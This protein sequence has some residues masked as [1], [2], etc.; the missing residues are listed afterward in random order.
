MSITNKICQLC[1]TLENLSLCTGCRNA[2]Y[3]SHEHQKT[4]WKVHKLSCRKAVSKNSEQQPGSNASKSI[5]VGPSANN[6]LSEVKVCDNR[7]QEESYDKTTK[8]GRPV[9]SKSRGDKNKKSQTP[10]TINSSTKVTVAATTDKNVSVPVHEGTAIE[11]RQNQP[12]KRSGSHKSSNKRKNKSQA[13]KIDNDSSCDRENA[14]SVSSNPIMVRDAPRVELNQALTERIQELHHYVIECMDK[15]GI[16]VVDNFLG[17]EQG[18]KILNEVKRFYD[19]GVF[20]QGQLVSS[21]N[22]DGPLNNPTIRGDMIMWMDGNEENCENIK[23]LMECVDRLVLLCK[24]K[25]GSYNINGR[26]KG[27]VAC[28]PG[29]DTKYLRHIDNPNADG[30]CMTCIY[31]IN[32]DWNVET[33]GGLLRIFPEGQETVANIVPKFDRLLFFWSDRRNPHEVQAA[34][35][36]RYA[37]TVWYF[38]AEERATAMKKISGQNNNNNSGSKNLTNQT[39]KQ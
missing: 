39:N 6:S 20:T 18:L 17:E 28:Y 11:R 7:F 5:V 38:D 36:C 27:M 32:K 26:T 10:N 37:I 8:S 19:S 22:T 4:D 31:Y 30:R 15:Y 16:C 3:C 34:K 25:L 12:G 35:R 9:S 23:L 2:W 33:D 14:N 29:N 24:G 13:P 21:A 1:G